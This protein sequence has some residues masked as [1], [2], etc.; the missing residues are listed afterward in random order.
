MSVNLKKFSINSIFLSNNMKVLIKYIT[1]VLMLLYV[2]SYNFNLF[3]IFNKTLQ[4]YVEGSYKVLS[5][6]L[7]QTLI[8]KS[9]NFETLKDSDTISESR[10]Q[11]QDEV[12]QSLSNESEKREEP[13][14]DKEDDET[15]SLNDENPQDIETPLSKEEELRDG[16]SNNI[17]IV[18][19]D[20][21]RVLFD[22]IEFMFNHIIDNNLF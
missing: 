21:F 10:D 5:N 13:P 8:L 3:F 9:D 14:K 19:K 2:L 7:L 6:K 12:D 18:E 4:I 17:D 22:S 16:I 20:Y 15:S 11:I 1:Y